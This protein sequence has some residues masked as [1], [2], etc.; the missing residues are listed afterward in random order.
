VLK[1][2]QKKNL[3]GW[4]NHLKT[5]EEARWS[6]GNSSGPEVLTQNRGAGDIGIG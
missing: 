3:Q 2:S 4:A 1:L 6:P 5:L